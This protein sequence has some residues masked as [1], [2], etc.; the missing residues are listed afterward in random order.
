MGGA[1]LP[2]NRQ[3]CPKHFLRKPSRVPSTLW[4]KSA[5]GAFFLLRHTL[6]GLAF[7]ARKRRATAPASRAALAT[8]ALRSRAEGLIE[9]LG[10]AGDGV[11]KVGNGTFWTLLYFGT[12][13]GVVAL[14]D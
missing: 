8:V 4:Q 3:W 11:A 1:A 2:A 12:G 13:R 14:R 5:D 6:V 9:S 7:A 10:S